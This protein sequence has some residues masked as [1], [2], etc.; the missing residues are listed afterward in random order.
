MRRYGNCKPGSASH[1]FFRRDSGVRSDRPG[2]E[3]H[4]FAAIPFLA[5]E[6][7]WCSCRRSVK[8]P[9]FDS[10]RFA[11]SIACR[12]SGSVE[13]AVKHTHDS[14]YHAS[15]NGSDHISYRYAAVT[16]FFTDNHSNLG[17]LDR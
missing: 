17:P 5:R 4:L 12:F 8:H 13:R 7:N 10:N 14:A 11:C 16:R 15:D 2:R 6:C 3:R 1:Q 9:D